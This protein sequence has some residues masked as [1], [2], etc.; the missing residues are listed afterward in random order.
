MLF[1]QGRPPLRIIKAVYP[2]FNKSDEIKYGLPIYGQ[3]IQLLNCWRNMISNVACEIM[4]NFLKDN[5]EDLIL[6]EFASILLEDLSFAYK[7]FGNTISDKAFQSVL[8]FNLL[9]ATH[10]QQT[11]GWVDIPSFDLWS[12]Y[13]HS[14]KGTLAPWTAALEH[15]FKLAVDGYFE[16]IAITANGEDCTIDE[17]TNETLSSEL[18]MGNATS[19]AK[20]KQL[21]WKLFRMLNK[22][23]REENTKSTTFSHQNWGGQMEMTTNQSPTKS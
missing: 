4:A 9:R 15:A 11:C 17:E 8:L 10:V 20:G 6:Q 22:M 7:D 2:T 21:N 13:I 23:T 3:A 5:C 19:A 18:D 1:P 14:V 16:K 12:K